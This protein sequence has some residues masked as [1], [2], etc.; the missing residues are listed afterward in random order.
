MSSFKKFAS[1][2]LFKMRFYHNLVTVLIENLPYRKDKYGTE[3]LIVD[4]SFI[5]QFLAEYK[6]IDRYDAIRFKK[7]KISRNK[8]QFNAYVKFET[9]EEAEKAIKELNFSLIDKTFYI[10]MMVI[11]DEVKKALKNKN[12]CIVIKNLLLD[13]Q[14]SQIYDALSN[15]YKKIIKV[16]INTEKNNSS[17]YCIAYFL[18][19]SVAVRAAS[20]LN[21]SLING[22]IVY[23]SLYNSDTK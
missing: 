13:I 12:N 1:I 20:E 8:V 15:L 4:D 19:E 14:S 16:D 5:R 23:V 9:L 3:F 21:E 2:P 6:I 7:K 11:N 18:E 17:K 22:Q 10:Q